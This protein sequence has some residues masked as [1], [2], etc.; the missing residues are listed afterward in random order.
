MDDKR[1]FVDHN[2]Y[3]ALCKHKDLEEN[4]D[5]CWD[6]LTEPVNWN[7]AKPVKYEPAEGRQA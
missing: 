3:C 1:K 5:P 7:S 4:Q 2:R 6:C